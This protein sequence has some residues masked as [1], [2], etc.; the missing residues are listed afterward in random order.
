MTIEKIVTEATNVSQMSCSIKSP[1]KDTIADRNIATGKQATI[2]SRSF[3]L[4]L[5]GK[6]IVSQVKYICLRIFNSRYNDR[7]YR[8]VACRVYKGV[9]LPA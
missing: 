2:F 9:A 4:D 1:T 7:P 8:L 5:T 3:I 6:G